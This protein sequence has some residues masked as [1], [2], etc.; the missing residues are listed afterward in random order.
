L[1]SGP[2]L[3]AL[4]HKTIFGHTSLEKIPRYSTDGSSADD[5]I[6]YL[7]VKK[8]Y[9]FRVELFHPRGKPEEKEWTCTI[10]DS[11]TLSKLSMVTKEFRSH[12]ICI[13]ALEAL[14]PTK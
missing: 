8:R 10:T 13:A 12:A 5:I 1:D 6:E 2:E 9:W 11:S 4:I 7:Q 3:D 14:S